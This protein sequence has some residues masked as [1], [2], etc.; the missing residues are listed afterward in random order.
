M[1]SVGIIG[2]GISGL[3][4]AYHLQQ[5]QIPVVIYEAGS[6][7]G[8][9]IETNR[10]GGY[11]AE[12]GP[13]SLLE[14][15]SSISDFIR[16]LG[17]E[18]RRRY[19]DAQAGNRFLVK[20][21]S[22]VAMPSSL[23]GFVRTPLFSSGAKMRLSK[24][25]FLPPAPPDQEESVAEFVVR[26][27]GPEFLDYAVNPLLAG[28]YAGDPTRL[29]L[30]HAFPKLHALE[31]RY[32]S[33]IRGQI[34]GAKERRQRGEVSKAHAKKISF[35]EGLQ[36]LTD[37]LSQRLR[38]AVHR[39][40]QVVELNQNAE[41]WEIGLRTVEGEEKH[42]HAA[43]VFA[44]SPFGFP[45]LNLR[46]RA[47]ETSFLREIK[48]APVTSLVLGFKRD[49]VAHPLDGFGVLV[50][51]IEPFRILGAIFSS[52]LFANR[53][54]PGHVLL[55]C[56]LGGM[57]D[58]ELA[59]GNASQQLQCTI[60][61]L[62]AL[63]GVRGEPTFVHRCC[64]EKAIPQYEVGYGRIKHSM[65]AL[66]RDAPGLFLAG[67]YKDGISL[68]DSIVSGMDAARKA[69]DHISSQANHHVPSNP[70]RSI[71]TVT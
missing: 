52:S 3:S 39:N 43:V 23:W 11:L 21:G 2:G 49:Q 5:K 10:E 56:Y 14:T 44:G 70:A 69:E 33:L 63:L 64:F 32:G 27:L 7:T 20:R 31:Q 12:C 71:I 51:G 22:I 55:T 17:L 53:A 48:Y 38:K 65:A 13:N 24:E 40:T 47:C 45:A 54:P 8:G 28:I 19:T 66:E 58:P 29:S 25:P 62:R 1:S 68:S 30:R 59:L 61:D 26:R 6:R 35:D 34:F 57:R 9:V 41:G 37:A 4:A 50:P 36:V 67:C 15:S 60:K 18:P 46:R 16:E 42:Q